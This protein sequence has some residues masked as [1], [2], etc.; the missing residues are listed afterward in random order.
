MA[1]AALSGTAA[2]AVP[3]TDKRVKGEAEFIQ[4]LPR[5][6]E[7][8]ET[9]ALMKRKRTYSELRA[10]LCRRFKFLLYSFE[11]SFIFRIIAA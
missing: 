1:T 10:Y 8:G 5:E 4:T 9:N 7:E 3:L 2:V 6:K 11:V